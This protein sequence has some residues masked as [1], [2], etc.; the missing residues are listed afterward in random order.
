MYTSSLYLVAFD[1][2]R[3]SYMN[4]Y[5]FDVRYCHDSPFLTNRRVFAMTDSGIPDGIKC[6]TNGNVYSGYGDELQV[7]VPWWD[8]PRQGSTLYR[9]GDLC[10]WPG[11]RHLFVERDEDMVG[12]NL[13]RY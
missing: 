12:S 9:S 4:R 8:S 6:D 10:F 3:S 5:A 1:N 2:Y 7:L 13:K 11:W